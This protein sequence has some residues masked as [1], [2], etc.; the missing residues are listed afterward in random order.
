MATVVK[1]AEEH[2]E[3]KPDLWVEKGQD[4]EEKFNFLKNKYVQMSAI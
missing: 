2:V 1:V 4:Y 3:G